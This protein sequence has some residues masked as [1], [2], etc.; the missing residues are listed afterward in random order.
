MST[1]TQRIP[2]LLLGISQQPDNLK[3]PGQVNN[4]ENV[5]PDYALGMLK[6]P[7]GKFVTSLKDASTAGRWFSILRD[8]NEKYVAQYDNN[9]FRIWSILDGSPRKVEMGTPGSDGVPAG[10]NYTNLQTDLLAYNAAVTTVAD[11]LEDLNEFG[12][13]FAETNDGQTG[14]VT[15][16]IDVT[17]TYNTD[18]NQAVKTGVVYDGTRYTLTSNGTVLGQYTTAPFTSSG[19]Y[20]RSGTTITV[21]AT[22]HGLATNNYVKLVFTSGTASSATYPITVTSANEF[23]VTDVVSGTTSGNVTIH[24]INQLGTERT[25]DYPL[26]KRKDLRIFELQTT[27]SVTHTAAQLTTATTNLTTAGTDYTTAV[28]SE[29][30]AETNYDAE[31]TACEITT[32]NLPADRV[33]IT[34]AGSGFTDG[35]FTAVTQAAA[36]TSGITTAEFTITV[37]GGAITAA[38]VT[39]DPGLLEGDVITLTGY[40][41]AELTFRRGAYLSGATANDI[42]LLTVNDF[43]FVLNK[44]RTARMKATE[45]A[46]LVNQAFVVISVVAYNANYTVTLNGVD[47]SYTTATDTSVKVEDAGTIAADL[48][49]DLNAVA[50]ITAVQVGPGVYISGTNPFTITTSG[51]AAE[52]GLYA[53]QD[54]INV[55]GRLPNQCRNGYIVKVYNSDIVDADDMWVKF[56]TKPQT[57]KTGTYTISGTTVTVTMTGHGFLNNARIPFNFTSG[58]ASNNDGVYQITVVDAN[59]FTLVIPSLTTTTGGNVTTQ[60]SLYGPGVWEETV[61]P[62]LQFELDEYTMPHQL[63]RQADGS[64][65]Y[66]P[67][68]W[69][70]RLVGDNTTNPVPSFIGQQIKHLFFYRNRFGFLS[71]E[72]IILSKSGDYFNFFAGSAQLVASDDPIDITATSRVPVNLTYAQTVSV[73][74]VL[75]S[76]NEQFLLSTDA[77]ILGPTTAKINTLSNFECDENLEAVSL[78][79]TLAFVSKTLLWSRVYELSNIR[80]EAPADSVEISNNV[81]ELIPANVDS[82]ISSPALSIFSL[83]EIGKKDLYQFRFYQVGNERLANTWYKWTLAGNLRDQFF[84]ETTFYAVCDDGTNVF[85]ESFDLT[86]SSEE[87]FLTLPTGEKTDVCMD[88]F[89]VNP[90]RTYN[91]TNQETTIHLPYTKLPNRDDD[92]CVVV[93]GGYIGTAVA[94]ADSIGAVLT[95]SSLTHAAGTVTVSGDYRGRN[96]IVGY[97]YDMILELPQ[98]FLGRSEGKQYVTDSTADLIIHRVKVNTGL[99]GPVTYSVDITGVSDW[100]NVVNVTLP[101]SYTLGN[102]NLAASAEHVV[103]VFQ[104]NSNLKF[105]IKGDTAFPVS[106]NSLTWEGNYNNRYYR[107]A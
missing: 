36:S 78:G 20:A 22:A 42:E 94:A 106:L 93:L 53:F 104:R 5:F 62:E 99:S 8:N 32:A 68:T 18:Y 86:Q 6:R 23:T 50:G 13:T 58:D 29:G 76:Q 102:V 84:D 92:I 97:L 33:E 34:T 28:T 57:E 72:N 70:D 65:K 80:K 61:A 10:C 103:P 69:T 55:T 71:K 44:Q 51:S 38:T 24:S 100:Q 60:L 43:T 14:K 48:T 9:T 63:V 35:T 89:T 77:D 56:N 45:S 83:G 47:Y 54:E 12:A 41:G 87:G 67:V 39:T 30:T 31:V 98:F 11:E 66:E 17:T 37:S 82:F 46:A 107:R 4:A 88:M 52:E 25:D 81:S 19:T 73:G 3:F 2:T 49:N 59:S 95:G 27:S 90:R 64:F 85:V 26:L 91:S 74:L 96:L 7:G 40:A 1:L 79:T 21:T 101:N 15:S 16:A 105:T 75:F